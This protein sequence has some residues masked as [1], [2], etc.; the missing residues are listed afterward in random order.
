MQSANRLRFLHRQT[1]TRQRFNHRVSKQRQQ[2]LMMAHH[3]MTMTSRH[4][5]TYDIFRR[6]IMALH[7]EV[8]CHHRVEIRTQ[9]AGDRHGF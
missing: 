6:A 3:L 4:R 2:N 1:L 9:V 8:G 7:V 5:A